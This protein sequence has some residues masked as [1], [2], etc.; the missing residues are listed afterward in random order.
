LPRGNQIAASTVVVRRGLT[1][2]QTDSLVQEVLER[3]GEEARA[4]LLAR[5]LDALA[6]DTQPG[7][8]TPRAVRSEADVFALDVARAHAIAARL[9]TRLLASPLATFTPGAAEL[10]REALGRLAPVLRALDA[11]IR[12]SLGRQDAA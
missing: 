6:L 9:E 4:D 1:V 11:V 5:R 8:H 12:T 7:L 2:R 10:L 3:D